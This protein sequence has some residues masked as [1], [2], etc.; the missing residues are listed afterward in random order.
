MSRFDPEKVEWLESLY[1]EPG[2]ERLEPGNRVVA[3]A[4]MD[5]VPPGLYR[6]LYEHAEAMALELTARCSCPCQVP[7]DEQ[8]EACQLVRAYRGEEA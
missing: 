1:W 6:E 8:C 3:E 7:P 5:L 4:E 2:I